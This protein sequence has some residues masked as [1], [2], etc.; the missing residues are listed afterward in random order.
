MKKWIKLMKFSLVLTM[1][2]LFASNSLAY[3][4]ITDPHA[5]YSLFEKPKKT[6]EFTELKDGT[7]LYSIP[8][9]FRPNTFYGDKPN[10]L[11]I[12]T[13]DSSLTGGYEELAV[14]PNAFS[15]AWS[16]MVSDPKKP[17]SFCETVIW[18]DQGI[19][20]GTYKMTVVAATGR[21][22]PFAMLTNKGF[23]GILP[24][25]P[26]ETLFILDD[27][28]FISIFETEFRAS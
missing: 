8:A 10:C 11:I 28:S 23:I 17:G 19:S 14:R 7:A 26:Q 3:T 16:F 18:F 1:G 27:I 15:N 21:S 25:S 13:G 9:G 22:Q 6:I 4:V 2:L 20:A 24:D 12:G 5:F